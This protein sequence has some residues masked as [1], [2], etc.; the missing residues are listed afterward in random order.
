MNAIHRLQASLAQNLFPFE[1]TTTPGERV[2]FRLFEALVAL[3][4]IQL[5]W[6]W[7]PYIQRIEAVVK[8]VGLAN[9]VD[10]SP[11]FNGHASYILSGVLVVGLLGGVLRRSPY[12][13]GI[14]MLAFHL[15]YVARFS[16][17]K[18]A[19]GSQYV[20][21][22]VLALTVGTAL[23]RDRPS[24]RQ[25][26][27]VG[28]LAFF[29]GLGY[30]CAGVCK[31]VAT[32]IDW[33]AGAHLMLWI[34]ERSI[35]VTSNSGEFALNP[36]QQAVMATPLLGTMALTFGLVAELLGILSWFER[37]RPWIFTAL[38]AM[39]IGIELTMNIYFKYNIYVLLL[40]AY[41]WG[42]GIDWL[43]KTLRASPL[44]PRKDLERQTS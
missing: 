26:F 14:A 10:V 25:R 44:T 2:F 30:T 16:L 9:Y 36:I 38:I 31:L 32:G 22:A 12:A 33:P 42:R 6:D 8:P 28:F 37:P 11:L 13:Y 4:A 15:L 27:V 17:G 43:A 20:G 29:Y 23:F 40:L 7:S 18:A 21:M 39:H 1:R 35:D 24:E 3:F 34:G 19:H 41:P 5:A